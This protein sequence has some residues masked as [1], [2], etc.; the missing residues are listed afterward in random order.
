MPAMAI[1][2]G[3]HAI[4]FVMMIGV[5]VAVGGSPNGADIWW[6]LA[7]GL[8]SAVG[9]SAVYTGY[10]RS[11]IAIVAPVV[12]VGAVSLPVMWSA[13]SGESL[14]SQAWYGVALGVVAIL[15]VSLSRGSG[16]GSVT[17]AVGYGLLGAAGLG[18]LLVAFGQSSDDSGVWIVVPSRASGFAL[19]VVMLRIGRH[20]MR[21]PRRSLPFV[22]PIAAL[23][24]LANAAYAVAVREGSLATIAVVASMF[25][26]ITV[27]LA[28]WLWKERIRPV[29]F[30]GI[31]LAMVAVGLIAAS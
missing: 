22:L 13:V 8:G 16:R 21:L 29:Q 11:R 20:P 24:S 18:F 6:G 9:L 4:G 7:A 23:G 17:T 15:L 19:L 28:W 26:A 27:L 3:A 10:A 14:A 5:A 30:G 12:G 1:S 25:P 31:A 2:A